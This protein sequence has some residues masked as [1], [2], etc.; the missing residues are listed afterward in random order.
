[1]LAVGFT[2]EDELPLGIFASIYKL[3]KVFET[4][5]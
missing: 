1:M 4:F 5:C 3:L 2:D